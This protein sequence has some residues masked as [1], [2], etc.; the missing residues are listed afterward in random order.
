MWYNRSVREKEEQMLTEEQINAMTDE[1]L[2]EYAEWL[3]EEEYDRHG[4]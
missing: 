4:L 2:A 3:H 1:E